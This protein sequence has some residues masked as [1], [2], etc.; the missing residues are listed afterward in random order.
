MGSGCEFLKVR[1]RGIKHW[2]SNQVEL[3]ISVAELEGWKAMDM[4]D[5]AFVE[6][7]GGQKSWKEKRV[8][9]WEVMAVW[10][11]VTGELC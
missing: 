4:R 10:D 3:G 9:M 5:G 2:T 1:K 11:R 6:Q 7:F 8:R